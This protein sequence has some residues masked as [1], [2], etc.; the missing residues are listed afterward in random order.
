MG[1]FP[2]VVNL[3]AFP[4]VFLENTHRMIHR[5]THEKL[6]KSYGKLKTHKTDSVEVIS[7][8]STFLFYGSNIHFRKIYLI[9]EIVT[10][11]TRHKKHYYKNCHTRYL[12]CETNSLFTKPTY[13][14]KR[15][16]KN[17][18]P[19]LNTVKYQDVKVT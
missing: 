11:I 17:V 6:E 5:S 7:A 4:G 19:A 18:M 12:L 14:G 2:L 8:K 9:S 15:R 10:E 16:V 1:R 13:K 3:T